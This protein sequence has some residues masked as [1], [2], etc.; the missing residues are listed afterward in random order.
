MDDF[1][2]TR[3]SLLAGIREHS[4][5]AWFEF[6][7]IYEPII[8]RLA[9]KK[10]LQDADALDVTQEVLS[11]VC[12]SVESWDA[13]KSKGTF[14]GWLYRV[15]ENATIDVFRRRTRQ[16]H[17]SGDTQMIRLLEESASNATDETLLRNEYR[18]E[19][20]EVA[21]KS[22]RN[23]FSRSS[24]NAFWL[25]SVDGLS[26]QA[27]AEEI[28]ISKGSVYVARCRV[29]ARIRDKVQRLDTL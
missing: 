10:G 17:G 23:E 18:R 1:P 28:Q 11:V 24:W 25:T 8:Y 4:H 2:E 14:G 12:K 29:M 6:I 16:L 20:F 13:N 26:I 21:A 3:D 7:K 9:C 5:E 19:L 27:A 22:V 15:M